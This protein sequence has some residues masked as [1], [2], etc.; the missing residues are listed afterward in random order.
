MLSR[1]DQQLFVATAVLEANSKE[2]FSTISF[3]LSMAQERPVNFA[4]QELLIDGLFFVWGFQG[5]AK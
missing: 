5:V 1:E 4:K 3:F 2:S